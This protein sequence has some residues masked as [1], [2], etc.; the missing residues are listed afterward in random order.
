MITEP[1]LHKPTTAVYNFAVDATPNPSSTI[2]VSLTRERALEL[3]VDL[4]RWVRAGVPADFVLHGELTKKE[5]P[6]V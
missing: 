5:A 6:N 4:A 1:K 2:C 3:V